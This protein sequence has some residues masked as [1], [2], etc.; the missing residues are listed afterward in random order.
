MNDERTAML[1]FEN[2]RVDARKRLLTRADGEPVVLTPKLFDTLLYLVENA[3]EVLEK[4][5]LMDAIWPG[6]IVEE[7]NLSQAISNLR[8]ILGDD[9]AVHRYIVTV[10]RRGYRFVAT[11]RVAGEPGPHTD[12]VAETV[13]PASSQT[14][15]SPTTSAMPEIPAATPAPDAL[16]E[17]IVAYPAAAKPE[18]RRKQRTPSGWGGRRLAWT[19]IGLVI[20]V[21]AISGAGLWRA[22]SKGAGAGTARTIA[23]LPFSNP[24]GNKDD[25]FFGDGVTEDM[26]NQ[27][28][29]ISD[30]RVVSR[31]TSMLYKGSSKSVRDIARELGVAYIL[32]GSVRRGENRFRINAELIDAERDQHLWART[33]DRDNRDILAVQ[34]EVATEIATALKARLLVSEKDQLEKRAHG[35]AEAYV[36]YLQGMYILRK[37]ISLG[38]NPYDPAEPHF[39]KVIKLDP[40]SP[41][42]YVGMAS[43]F[44]SRARLGFVPPAENYAQAESF[45][46]KALALDGESVDVHIKL[47]ELRGPGQWNW[48][49]AEKSAKRAI[50]LNPGNALAWDTYRMAFLEPAGR[51]SEAL[52][53]QQRAVSLDPFNPP[54]VWRLALLHAMNGNCDEAVRLSRINLARDPTFTIH[55]TVIASCME[56]Q[57]NFA[58]AIAENR[59]VEGY[60][61][62]KPFLDELEKALATQGEKGYR[63]SKLKFQAALAATR[64]DAWYFAASAAILAGER[65]EGFRYLDL[66]IKAYDRNVIQLKVDPEFESVRGDPRYL[67]ALKRLHLD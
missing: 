23:V 25:E 51:L 35:N 52:V 41:L 33:Y 49:E 18:E 64:N 16:A 60:W 58:A 56:R 11:V 45:L 28:A 54:I 2:F 26:V 6:M 67:A 22:Q 9:G 66:A 7:N 12:T 32:E 8:R 21:V 40:T 44:I 1:E 5:R 43:Y 29:Q 14:A 17:K 34:S 47:A 19:G 48:P 39:R 10:P 57:G 20:M 13:R 62:P 38:K 46:L 27:L 59:L 30:L 31:T 42:G 3:G 15:S 50:E 24:G 63:R 4:D 61:T 55:H 37:R 36:E 53:A 65:D